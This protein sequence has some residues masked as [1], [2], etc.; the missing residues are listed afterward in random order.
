M[1]MS[2]LG[3]AGLFVAALGLGASCT[4]G[5]SA[6]A[7]ANGGQTRTYFIA[8]EEVVWDYAPTGMNRAAGRPFQGDAEMLMAM[9]G[10]M[11]LGHIYKKTLFFEYTDDTFKTRKPRPPEWEHL[12]SLGPLIRAEVGDT[13]HVVFKN[14]GHFP[15]TLHPHGVLYAKAS[16]GAVYN[17]GSGRDP[18]VPPGGTLAYDWQVPERAGPSHDEGSS[19][20][21]MYHSHIDEEKDV[22]SGLVGPMIVTAR[23]RANPNATPKDVDRELVA[24]FLEVDENLSWHIDENNKTYAIKGAKLH[25]TDDF[26][27][28]VGLANFKETINGFIFNHTPGLT[29]K[30]GE[31]VRWYLMA[32]TNFEVHAPH[33]HGNTVIARHMRTDVTSLLPMDMVVADMIPD[34]AGTWLFHCHTG[35][36]LRAGMIATYVVTEH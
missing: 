19:I 6:T 9:P 13:I 5:G 23:G 4:S 29:V 12:G 24:G 25:K 14:N 18:A 1:T 31:R 8:A 33:W 21:W 3:L 10:P 20:L 11:S 17:D 35:P 28:P 22:N 36:H 26:T 7:T 16:E 2:H 34:N 27:D 32:T 15:A 30:K